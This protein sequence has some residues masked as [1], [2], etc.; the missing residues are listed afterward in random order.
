VF[1]QCVTNRCYPSPL[2]FGGFPK[3]VTISTNNVVVHGIPDSRPFQIGDLISIDVSVFFDGY[4]GDTATTFLLGKEG[5]IDFDQHLPEADQ[6]A[7]RLLRV[8]RDCLNQAISVC[9]PGIPLEEI[10]LLIERVAISNGFN[11]IP[12]VCGH[13][14]GEYLHGPPDIAHAPIDS[15]DQLI[16]E[17]I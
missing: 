10:G 6:N 8:G 1:T 4:H 2:H 15:D 14:I 17:S 9:K 12:A 13:S 16:G 7:I 5:P 3:C 11:V